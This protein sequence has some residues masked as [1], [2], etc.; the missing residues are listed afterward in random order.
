MR[1]LVFFTKDNL[2]ILK[3]YLQWYADRTFKSAPPLFNQFFVIHRKLNDKSIF[4]LMYNII[5]HRT[6]QANDILFNFLADEH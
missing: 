3:K 4:P 5:T 2:K 6:E 1:V